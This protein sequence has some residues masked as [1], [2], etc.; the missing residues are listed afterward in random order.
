VGQCLT[1]DRTILIIRCQNEHA[2]SQPED[3]STR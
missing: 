3:A 1:D 2:V